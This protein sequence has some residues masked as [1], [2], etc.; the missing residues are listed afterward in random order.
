MPEIAALLK[1]AERCEEGPA[2]RCLDRD[3]WMSMHAVGSPM[4]WP[5]VTDSIDAAS[6]LIPEYNEIDAWGV[7][8]S[9]KGAS[10]W[11]LF[12]DREK[13]IKTRAPTPPLALCA[14]SLRVHAMI[15]TILRET[16]KVH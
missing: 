3:I 14:I 1:L 12:A 6:L 13:D 8:H 7:L 9:R 15:L 4:S 11:V 5:M 16:G 10:A 2:S